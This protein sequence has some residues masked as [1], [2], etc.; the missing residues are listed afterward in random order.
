MTNPAPVPSAPFT[1]PVTAPIVD[2]MCRVHIGKLRSSSNTHP[3]AAQRFLDSLA[4]QAIRADARRGKEA[5]YAVLETRD[6][7]VVAT[8]D[9]LTTREAAL[10][11][12]N[13]AL[14]CLR[15]LS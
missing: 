8:S 12:A 5:W 4:K 1:E 7:E 10:A 6:G 3:Q 14:A 2:D 13:H 9:A 15:S 11:A